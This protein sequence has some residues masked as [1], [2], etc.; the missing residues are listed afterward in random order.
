MRL[1][2][3]AAA[4]AAFL[5]PAAPAFAGDPTMPLWQVQAGMRCTGLLG[6]PG[7][8]D[9]LVRR[10]GAR[11]GGRRGDGRSGEILIG[12]SG[13]AVD[14]TGIGP[15]F[16]GSP[17]YCP[18]ARGRE[19]VI[20]AISRVDQRVRRQGRAGDA[21]R[22]DHRHAGGRARPDERDDA[23]DGEGVSGEPSPRMKAAMASAKPIAAPLSRERAQRAGR[24]RADE[25]RG[26]GRAAGAGGAAGAARDRSRR[27]RCSR[28]RRSRSATRTATCGRA[29][30]A[31]S[32]TST[33]TGCG[34]SATSSRA[35][36]GARCCCRTP[37]SSGS[38]TT[39][40]SS[41]AIG[42]DLQAR[43]VRA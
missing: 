6:D 39:R 5:V 15:G 19:R 11:R 43:G 18:D 38:S 10:A 14:A 17:I 42:V 35:S 26:E 22:R 34:S 23:R 31:R 20:G 9:Q 2:P 37:T 41:G 29:R 12:V 4:V 8:D 28:A 13:P 21:D 40:C 24:E 7:H 36:G 25:G 30:S 16:S 27:R 33:A 1:L 3:L 32:P